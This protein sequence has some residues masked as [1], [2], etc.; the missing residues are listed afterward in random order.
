MARA[1]KRPLNNAFWPHGGVAQLARAFGSYPKCHWFKSN[2]RYQF[3][4]DGQAVKT[5]PFHGGY[6]GSNPVEVANSPGALVS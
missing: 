3:W 1:V 2:Y 4:P 5:P 6:T